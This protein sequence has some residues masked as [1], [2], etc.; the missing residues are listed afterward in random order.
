MPYF[1]Y[2]SHHEF[3]IEA[4]RREIMESLKAVSRLKK[5][6]GYKDFKVRLKGLS[7]D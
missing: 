1:A 4:I 6:G 2:R 7:S 5:I 3:I